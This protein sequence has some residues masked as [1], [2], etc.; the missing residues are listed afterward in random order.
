MKNHAPQSYEYAS[1]I[2]SEVRVKKSIA[3][4]KPRARHRAMGGSANGSAAVAKVSAE[5]NHVGAFQSSACAGNHACVSVQVM[6]ACHAVATGPLYRLSAY[7]NTH[8]KAACAA[9]YRG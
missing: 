3:T 1:F 9:M 8:A 6:R 5:R 4:R 7:T 2:M